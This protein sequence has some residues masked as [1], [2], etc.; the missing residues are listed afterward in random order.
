LS[1]PDKPK[2]ITRSKDP[3]KAPAEEQPAR[4][5]VARGAAEKPAAGRPTEFRVLSKRA[6][7][8]DTRISDL[9]QQLKK[10]QENLAKAD[11]AAVAAEQRAEDLAA[12][13][14]RIGPLE[15]EVAAI[16]PQLEESRRRLKEA[17]L[18]LKRARDERD[19]FK[20]EAADA[21]QRAAGLEARSQEALAQ[22][23]K[24]TALKLE[25]SSFRLRLDASRADLKKAQDELHAQSEGAVRAEAVVKAAESTRR[26]LEEARRKVIELSGEI[27]R[28]R[29]A[30]D[31]AE[32]D[33]VQ[34]RAA[35]AD[36]REKLGQADAKLAEGKQQVES[37]ERRLT[38]AKDASRRVEVLERELAQA[39]QVGQRVEALERQLAEA[40]DAESKA[41]EEA[42]RKAQQAASAE[43]RL[44]GDVARLEGV[45]SEQQKSMEALGKKVTELERRLHEEETRKPE[46]PPRAP[47]PP[48]APV[49][50]AAPAPDPFVPPTPPPPPKP[51]EAIPPAQA[52]PATSGTPETT[53][54]PQN[55]FGPVGADGQQIYILHELLSKDDLGVVYI[56]SERAT[57]RKFMAQFM[58]GQA[59]E[60]QTQAIERGMEKLISLPHPN[61]LHVQ[62]TGRRKNRLY[63]MMDFVEAPTLGQA[64]IREI[65]RICAILRDAASA[66]HYAH[67]EGIFHGGVNPDTI[68]VGKDGEKDQA[69]VKEFGLGFLQELSLPAATGTAAP[70]VFRNPAYLPPEQVRTQKSPLNPAI[71]V[72]GLGATLY[73]ALAG[74][75][76]FEGKDAVQISKRVMI[77]DPIPVEKIRSEV[78]GA[79]GTIVRRAMAKERGVRYATAQDMADALSRY[80]DGA[81]G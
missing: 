56:A 22:M 19:R 16:R 77:Q 79:V 10:A 5:T 32:S 24:M 12:A 14:A 46:P 29:E 13:A 76:P 57:G 52:V 1:Q 27:Q 63:V 53:L 50:V 58:A 9:N 3:K 40:K 23:A 36:L 25:A 74:R 61:I 62:G 7:E 60:E 33:N 67:E 44:R 49:A 68:L 51:V 81:R 65:P 4:G 55:L 39:A 38:E 37:L 78:P 35:A 30:R 11:A 2:P 45:R 64:K 69:L 48:P 8:L 20:G 15:Q 72:Y 47:E 34:Q 26:D 59:G 70:P 41:R 43:E 66:I 17:Q 42:S 28:L 6:A 80:L 71:D 54:R 73:G 21:S 75:P 31:K 18:E